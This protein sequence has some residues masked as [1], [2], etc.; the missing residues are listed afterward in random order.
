[1]LKRGPVNKNAAGLEEGAQRMV[2]SS[3]DSSAA[4]FGHFGLLSMTLLL[5]NY[6]I[7]FWV[8]GF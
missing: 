1:M 4:T 8:K 5:I 6:G 7:K 2:R 3:V